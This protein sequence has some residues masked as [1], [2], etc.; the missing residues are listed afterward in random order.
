M[1][2][3]L[4]DAPHRKSMLLLFMVHNQDALSLKIPP[5][6]SRKA[7]VHWLMVNAGSLLRNQPVCPGSQTVL[8]CI[9]VPQKKI[10]FH[11]QT[12]HVS[13]FHLLHIHLCVYQW[14]ESVSSTILAPYGRAI[15]EESTCVEPRLTLPTLIPILSFQCVQHQ[16]P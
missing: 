5:Q 12:Q 9:L 13:H 10:T 6:Y 8:H 3:A 7:H 15:A 2:V 16:I 14:T 1:E 11:V 4:K